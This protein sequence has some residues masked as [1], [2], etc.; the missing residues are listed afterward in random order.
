M[1]AV[2]LTGHQ[3]TITDTGRHVKTQGD[4][5][6]STLG[7]ETRERPP[8]RTLD[9]QPPDLPENE[10]LPW[11]SPPGW[12]AFCGSLSKP[13]PLDQGHPGSSQADRAGKGSSS[14]VEGTGSQRQGSV[15]DHGT[16]A[17]H[18]EQRRLR[19]HRP[20]HVTGA[21]GACW[22]PWTL[23]GGSREGKVASAWVWAFL[24][25]VSLPPQK[26]SSKNAKR[27]AGGCGGQATSWE[28]KDAPRRWNLAQP[29][30]QLWKAF[31]VDRGAA[32]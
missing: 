29:A 26:H 8:P 15:A 31:P 12:K 13:I 16:G 19:K 11:L 2:L 14:G 23:K 18:V 6:I 4:I 24:R 20:S 3:D 30:K 7:S 9:L 21:L 17:T 10:R 27:C 5:A 1:S 25:V 22:G 32:K 28:K